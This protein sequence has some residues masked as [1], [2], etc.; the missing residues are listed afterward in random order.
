[1]NYS[2]LHKLLGGSLHYKKEDLEKKTPIGWTAPS[3]GLVDRKSVV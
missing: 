3:E 2:N 1:M